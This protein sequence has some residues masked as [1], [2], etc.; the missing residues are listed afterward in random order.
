MG[1]MGPR[2]AALDAPAT[3]T[4]TAPARARAFVALL[5]LGVAALAGCAGGSGTARREAGSTVRVVAAFYPLAFVLGRVGGGAVRVDD[6]TPPGV[7]PHDVELSPK[8]AG[9]V[10]GATLLVYVKG[11][12]PAVDAVAGSAAHALDVATVTPL[13]A[14]RKAVDGSTEGGRDPHVWLDPVLVQRLAAAVGERLAA[15]DPPRAEGYRERAQALV[16]ELAG[17]DGAFRTGLSHCAR[18]ELVTSHAAFGYLADRYGLSQVAI[19][20]FTPEAEPASGRVAQVAGYARAHHVT[21]VYFESL[22]SPKVAQTVASSIGARTAVLDPIETRPASGDYLTAMRADL[23]T[24]R[25]G[26]GCS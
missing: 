22:V 10:Q 11:M 24:L 6:L 5:A 25:A 9:L 15:L 13:V 2:R 12:A 17:L 23:A 14:A 18:R 8:Q 4:A 16:R 3:R 7:E 19:T 20:G 21:T 26:Q 1:A